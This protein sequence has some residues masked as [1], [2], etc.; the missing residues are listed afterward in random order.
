MPIPGGTKLEHPDD[1]L[2]AADLVV[3]AGDLQA[4]DEA[5]AAIEVKGAPL[6]PALTAAL[7]S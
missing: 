6:S 7:N 1:N 4:I 2:P 5:F 3:T